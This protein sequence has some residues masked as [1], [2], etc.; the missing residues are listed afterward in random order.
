M[1]RWA[2]S[3]WVHAHRHLHQFVGMRVIHEGSRSLRHEFV[4]VGLARLYAW[5]GETGDAVHAIGHTLAVPVHAGVLGQFVG[6]EY[7]HL[8]AFDH[9]NRRARALPVVTP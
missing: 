8:V 1:N 5:L 4:Y 2:L 9:F 6:D 3:G 7:T